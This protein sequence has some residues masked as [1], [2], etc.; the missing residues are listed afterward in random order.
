M[1][2]RSGVAETVAELPGFTRGLAF[3]GDYAFVGLSQIRE[4]STFGDLS[5]TQRLSADERKCG[6]WVVQLSTGAIVAFLEFERRV[7]EIFDVQLLTGI[8]H[9]AV[10]GLQKDD[11][12]HRYVVPSRSPRP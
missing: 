3:A 12:N 8:R 11:V 2:E 5:I 9:P 6:V 7:Q 10:V 4:S 1:D